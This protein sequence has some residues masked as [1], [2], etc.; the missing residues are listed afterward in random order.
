MNNEDKILALLEKMQAE[1]NSRFDRL[2]QGQ[3]RLEKQYDELHFDFINKVE[4][5]LMP[6]VEILLDGQAAMQDE[7]TDI[8]ARLTKLP[9]IEDDVSALKS[10]AA[11]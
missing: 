1:N 7:L 3:E 11:M 5:D 4:H 8:R 6:K 10:R 9:G 2:E